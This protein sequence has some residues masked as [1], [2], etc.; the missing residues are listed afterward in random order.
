MFCE[1]SDGKDNVVFID[2]LE[3][4]LTAV[5]EKECDCVLYAIQ[6][7]SKSYYLFPGYVRIDNLNGGRYGIAR[8][9]YSFK[10][11]NDSIDDQFVFLKLR[12]CDLVCETFDFLDSM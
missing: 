4:L 9:S 8:F 12:K 10:I 1:S 5:S 3:A 7:V 6:H 11:S 2:S